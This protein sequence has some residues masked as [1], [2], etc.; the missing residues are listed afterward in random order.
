MRWIR[1]V[2]AFIAS[3]LKRLRTAKEAGR[4]ETILEAHREADQRVLE[5]QAM[6]EDFRNLDPDARERVRIEHGHYR[7]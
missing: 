6:A 4:T 3:L 5:A 1:V 2:V 7:D